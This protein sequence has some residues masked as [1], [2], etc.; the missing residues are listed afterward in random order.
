[1]QEKSL[2]RSVHKPPFRQGLVG[3]QSSISGKKTRVLVSFLLEA[4]RNAFEGIAKYDIW[5]LY[6]KNN[7]IKGQNSNDG[8]K[9]L[10][11]E[12]LP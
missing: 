12:L 7:K 1:M 6:R 3:A 8:D 9:V 10:Q 5:P 4:E 2:T 11:A